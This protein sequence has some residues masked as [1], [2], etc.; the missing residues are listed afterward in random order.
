MVQV[1]VLQLKSRSELL[2]DNSWHS[3]WLGCLSLKKCCQSSPGAMLG[4]NKVVSNHQQ[5]RSSLA[6]HPL[7][8]CPSYVKQDIG[9]Y[10]WLVSHP[11]IP[12]FD[13]AASCASFELSLSA[14]FTWFWSA[15]AKTRKGWGVLSDLLF[16]RRQKGLF[17]WGRCRRR[18]R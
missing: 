5:N 14:D 16:L 4:E 11:T 17:G 8:Y 12:L 6:Q 15:I 1:F 9:P 7:Y 13:T 10:F 3:Y 2:L 18:K